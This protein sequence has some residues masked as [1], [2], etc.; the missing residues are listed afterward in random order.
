MREIDLNLVTNISAQDQRELLKIRNNK[1]IRKWMYTEHEISSREHSN[2]IQSL[3]GE[4][5]RIALAMFEHNKVIGAFNIY[6]INNLHKTCEWGWFID[7]LK[8]GGGLG[9]AIEYNLIDFIFTELKMYKQIVEVL[10]ENTPV[11]NLHKKFFFKEE[12]FKRFH[13]IKEGQRTSCY[14][15][16][17]LSPD[18]EMQKDTIKHKSE[19]FKI[20]IN[21]K[22]N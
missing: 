5:S 21:L 1:E 8:S 14:V 10:E 18:W 2:W 22:I 16:G 12:G 19:D 3:N 17:L 4:A 20:N 6:N 11:I 9:S 13:F 7:P 15:L